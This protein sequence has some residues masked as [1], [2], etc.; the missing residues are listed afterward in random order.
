MD[1]YERFCELKK[2]T[3]VVGRVYGTEDFSLYLY[4]LVKMTKPSTV[5]ELGTGLGSTALWMALALQENNF[6]IIHTVDDGSQWDMYQQVVKDFKV[7]NELYPQYIKNVAQFFEVSDKIN[8]INEKIATVN[9]TNIDILF[10][11]FQH[12]PHSVLTCVADYLG[13]MS[14]NS[15]I[16]IDSASTYYPS[17]LVL[18]NLIEQ[19]NKN[20]I[21]QTVLEMVP[22]T[23]RSDFISK[24]NCSKFELSHIIENKNRNQN[25]TA[26]IKISPKDIFPQPRINIRF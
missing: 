11:D 26:A 15:Y 17:F 25:S 18:E 12:D 13:R 5:L 16:F 7:Y 2:F 22:L 4:S 20:N 24:I 14:D 8:F 21:P 6:G 19:F 9:L 23:Q 10:S 1:H 3:D